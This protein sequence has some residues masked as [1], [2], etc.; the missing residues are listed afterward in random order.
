MIEINEDLLNDNL[1]VVDVSHPWH[2]HTFDFL[3][4]QQLPRIW[5]KGEKHKVQVNNSHFIF[6][7]R[8]IH[9]KGVD[10]HL[11]KCFTCEEVPS[12]PNACNESACGLFFGHLINQ[13]ALKVGYC[14]PFMLN[15]VT[16]ANNILLMIFIWFFC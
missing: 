8:K 9:H 14:D 11:W 7:S 13:K 3:N 6:I 4:I 15:N 5:L 1:F 2:E 10:G 12:I 16:H